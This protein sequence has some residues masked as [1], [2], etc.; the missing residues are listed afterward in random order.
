MVPERSL[1]F[2]CLPVSLA[3]VPRSPWARFLVPA[4]GFAVVVAGGSWLR[5]VPLY[6]GSSIYAGE[7]IKN[8]SS[9]QTVYHRGIHKGSEFFA[10]AERAERRI[11]RKGYRQLCPRHVRN[12]NRHSCGAHSS[13][14]HRNH[15]AAVN[16]AIV[17]VMASR[18]WWR[19]GSCHWLSARGSA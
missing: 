3:F 6:T 13:S 10:S 16:V 1:F 7:C 18:S 15:D 2:S 14:H 9:I 17:D 11:S 5:G 4:C 12:S 19:G 8:T